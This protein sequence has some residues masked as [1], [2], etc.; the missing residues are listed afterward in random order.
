MQRKILL[1]KLLILGLCAACVFFQNVRALEFLTEEES[2]EVGTGLE[3][4]AGLE[5]KTKSLPLRIFAV[6]A[7]FKASDGRQSYD[8]IELENTSGG[9]LALM[10][11]RII[12]TNSTGT[13]QKPISFAENVLLASERL[14]L[15]AKGSVESGGTD[16]NALLF[17]FGS[18]GLAST[19]G[20]IELWL[21]EEKQEELCWGKALCDNSFQ[22][23]DTSEAANRSIV[24]CEGAECTDVFVLEKY[25]PELSKNRLEYIEEEKVEEPACAVLR[26]SE[27]YT[28]YSDSVAEQFIEFYNPLDEAVSLDR[29]LVKAARKN[30]TLSGVVSGKGYY[31]FRNTELSM[32]KNPQTASTLM[33]I[34][35]SGEVFNSLSYPHGQKRGAVYALFFENGEEV[36]RISYRAT[37]G[38]ENIFQE[39]R[40]CPEGSIINPLTGNCI[41]DLEA[42][43]KIVVCPEGKY[44]NPMTGRC[45]KIEET[46][47]SEC[48]EGYYRNP[49]T[50]RCKK[51][52]SNAVKELTACAEGYE[53]NP[54]TNR[55]RKIRPNMGADYPVNPDEGTYYNPKVFV[56]GVAL[57][58]L[59]VVGA[60]FA[61][62]QFKGEIAMAGRRV[63]RVLREARV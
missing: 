24:R 58:G 45:K 23:F 12:Y 35:E 36:W 10:D 18:A 3:A 11:Y 8:F 29:C 62:F 28:Y 5:A 39:F 43:E 55:C 53:R 7:G 2:E 1:R 61:L 42:V 57:A 19:A 21:G 13:T 40:S 27:I 34:G 31:V 46:K 47:T 48:K 52:A 4:E 33:L 54:E 22:K 26:F 16:G 37:P 6:N 32:T 14:L 20:K 51:I 17:D 59:L 50:G 25:Y 9:N 38:R 60:G 41:K 44:L 56:A 63:L 49:L 15:L 30:L